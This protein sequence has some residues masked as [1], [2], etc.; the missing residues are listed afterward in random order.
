MARFARE[1]RVV[2]RCKVSFERLDE[3]I[4]AESEDLSK[5]GVF[6]R[7]EELLPVG[8]VVELALT[9]PDSA[10]FRV[11]ARVAHLLS[12]SAARAL[13]RR[14]G[15]GFEFLE[16]D[17]AGR[18]QLVDYLDELIHELTPPPQQL[19]RDCRVVVAEP[20]APLLAR[21]TQ[22][23]GDAGFIVVG[24]GN[25]A[26]AYTACSDTRPDVLIA[27]ASMPGMDGL[28]LARMLLGKPGLAELPIVL[29]SEDASDIT[30]LQAY[31]LGVS[32]FVHRPFTDEEM[33]IRLRRLAMRQQHHQR[34]DRASLRG[35][36][37]PISVATVL[38]LL[39]F[40]RTSGILVLLRDEEAARLFVAS[41]KIVKV[42]TSRPDDSP[43]ERMLWVLD[44][45]D[46]N[47]E[48]SAC[49]VVGGDELGWPTARLLL[50][51]ARIRDEQGR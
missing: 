16:Q 47:F 20:S 7:T 39:E 35:S 27:A 12:P 10:E 26:E 23:L 4:V 11:I 48:F 9:L 5:R 37:G 42:E 14:T 8:A 15:M 36:L 17:N 3:T 6:V 50:E 38:S 2:T 28:T 22:A 25:G 49:E 46:G 34:A 41:G 24:T 51:H 21:L 13:G 29:T 30:R 32:D 33:I 44:W 1:Q 18:Q 31:R 40:E 45:V 43:L 19:P